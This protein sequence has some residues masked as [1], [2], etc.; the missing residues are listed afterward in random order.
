MEQD[1]PF[2]EMEA[3]KQIMLLLAPASGHIHFHVAESCAL[4]AGDLVAT[5]DLDDPDSISK[6]RPFTGGWPELSPPQ[7]SSLCSLLCSLSLSVT[8]CC[9]A[10]VSSH[11]TIKSC[12]CATV[13][14]VARVA[15][16]VSEGL[17]H[18]YADA[19][20][21]ADMV[22]AGFSSDVDGVLCELLD[23][24]HTPELPFAVWE[25]QWG[26][27][28][29][30]IPAAVSDRM[31][32]IIGRARAAP[33]AS[34]SFCSFPAAELR[35]AMLDCVRSAPIP[36]QRILESATATPLA[37]V[38]RMHGGADALARS[39]ARNVFAAFLDTEQPFAQCRS[40]DGEAEV[41]DALRREHAG[42]PQRVLDVLLSHRALPAK[43]QLVQGLLGAVVAPCPQAFRQELAQLAALPATGAM[44]AVVQRAQHLLEASLLKQLSAEISSALVPHGR[45][46][47]GTG[48][49]GTSASLSVGGVESG[50]VSR[51]TSIASAASGGT[52]AL[53][54]AVSKVAEE[55]QS[56]ACLEDK[57]GLSRFLP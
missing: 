44:A 50:V 26:S 52:R 12:G 45:E 32:G 46:S 3:M 17:H 19:L 18:M 27:L 33:E 10:T 25:E 7:V 48:G 35:A 11:T 8:S 28:K 16:V 56:Q 57:C 37:V 38:A 53:K 13:C 21:S 9:C 47:G 22:L 39:V 29:G 42:Q 30:L 54:L 15:Q 1:S 2:A 49:D 40:G 31:A 36:E 43:A 23:V 34:G 24:L 41:I 4:A 55:L 14:K 5:L 6:G 51:S 20:H